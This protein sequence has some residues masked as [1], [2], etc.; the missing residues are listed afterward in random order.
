MK[1]IFPTTWQRHCSRH[2]L[3]NFKAKH[4]KVILRDYFWIVVTAPNL[5]L[6]NKAMEKLKQMDK[7]AH[8]YLEDIPTY[9]WSKHAFDPRTKS[10]HITNNVCESFN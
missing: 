8:K 4:P 9:R 5:F 10:P 1:Q 7:L 3:N 6:F 2:L